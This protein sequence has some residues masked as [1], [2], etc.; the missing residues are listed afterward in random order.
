[1]DV[2]TITLTGGLRLQEE[3][4]W[5]YLAESYKYGQGEWCRIPTAPILFKW[6]DREKLIKEWENGT[7]VSSGIY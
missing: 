6:S 3:T 5:A 1:M 4:Q 2:K 7:F